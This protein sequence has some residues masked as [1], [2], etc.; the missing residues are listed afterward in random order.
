MSAENSPQRWNSLRQGGHESIGLEIPTLDTGVDTGFGTVRW[1]LGG[2][3]E[4]RLLLPVRQTEVVHDVD[5][6]DA[7]TITTATYHL[8]S[9]AIRY[10]DVSCSFPALEAVF[11]EVADEII[12]RIRDGEAAQVSCRTTLEDFRALLT[13]S[14]AEIDSQRISGLV[15][16]LLLLRDLLRMDARS[17]LLW[18][19]PLMERHDFRAEALAIEV[20]TSS[21]VSDLSV[22]I[23]AIDQLQEP[24]GGELVLCL[25][26]L[27]RAPGGELTVASLASEVLG[28][29]SEPLSVRQLLA[30]VGC[31]DPTSD[32]WNRLAFR[33]EGQM[34][35]EVRDDFPRVVPGAFAAGTVP[36]GIG[37]LSY[38]LD[39]ASAG[40]FQID[41]AATR[42]YLERLIACLP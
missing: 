22:R 7:L 41:A 8:G 23:S 17:W 16:E 5:V 35:Y 29:A 1:A 27:E 14:S 11:G 26:Q 30:S 19:G 24:A 32:A 18:R 37:E 31:P 13:S 3:G 10:I 42:S 39:L 25:S 9:T 20:K 2:R 6:S 21:R 36:A 33:S 40:E 38:V 4:P 12:R 15:G 28:A 34:Y